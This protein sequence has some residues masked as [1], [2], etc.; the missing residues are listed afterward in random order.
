MSRYSRNTGSKA[1]YARA[2]GVVR[3]ERRV[4]VVDVG[5]AEKS[6]LVSGVATTV[7]CRYKKSKGANL[8]VS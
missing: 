1:A 7:V 8:G 5:S 2:M 3:K 6:R 4:L